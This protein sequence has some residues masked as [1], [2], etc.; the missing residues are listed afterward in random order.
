MVNS[1][2][3]KQI[4]RC[5]RR[6]P[7]SQFLSRH[8]GI[9]PKRWVISSQ[10]TRKETGTKMNVPVF[11]NVSVCETKKLILVHVSTD[12]QEISFLKC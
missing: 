2:R 1:E 5:S 9:V 3:V 6:I 11:T 10:G 8:R 7:C 12:S 4:V